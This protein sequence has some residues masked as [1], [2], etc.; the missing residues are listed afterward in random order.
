MG[1]AGAEEIEAAVRAGEVGRALRLADAVLRTPDR[2][3]R[4][5]AAGALAAAYAARGHWSSAA[6]LYGDLPDVDSALLR[7]I[8]LLMTGVVDDGPAP[9]GGAPPPFTRS[10]ELLATGLRGTLAGS[11]VEAFEQLTESAQ[12]ATARP[13]ALVPDSAHAVAAVVAC[14]LH[15]F[16][17]AAVL[18]AGAIELA[19]GEELLA[20][21]HRLLSAWVALRSGRWADA[22]RMLAEID[23]SSLE[24][25]DAVAAAAIEAGLALRTG[26]LDRLLAARAQIVQAVNL[27]PVDLLSLPLFAELVAAAT[28]LEALGDLGRIDA[29]SIELLERVDGAPLWTIAA[30]WARFRGAAMAG[31][32]D[33]AAA[34]HQRLAAA[35]VPRLAPLVAAATTWLEVVRGTV[36]RERVEAAATALE[37]IGLRWEAAQLIGSAAVRADDSSVARALLTRARDL[38]ASLPSLG[39]TD[40]PVVLTEREREIGACLL[41]GLSHKEIGAHLFISAKTVEHHVAR[42][43]TKLGA[44]SRAELLTL[45]RRELA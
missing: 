10:L 16:D 5:R 27:H 8:A 31:D 19:V 15:E 37:G 38:R 12:L 32:A 41:D 21:R 25:R 39:G 20:T 43:R 28:R 7:S 14:E 13:D 29:A 34:E 30:R 4:D 44:R 1:G 18:L 2:E 22:Q 26:D 36:D 9:V 33:A 40:G 24:A 42:I 6:A 45:V 3:D 35:P 23:P 17:A 11:L